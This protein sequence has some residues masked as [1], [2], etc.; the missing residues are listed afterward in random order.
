MVWTG[1]IK[2]FQ[3]AGFFAEDVIESLDENAMVF[4][5]MKGALFVKEGETAKNR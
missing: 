5:D 1:L 2:V 3:S 4:L